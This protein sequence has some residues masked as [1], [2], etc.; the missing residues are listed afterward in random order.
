MFENHIKIPIVTHSDDWYKF[1]TVGLT[2][3]E[4]LK[5]GLDRPLA[6]GIGSSEVGKVC[7]VDEYRPTKAELYHEKIGSKEIEKSDSKFAFHGRHM[8]PHIK[9]F[10]T[11]YDNTEDGYLKI[12]DDWKYKGI[13]PPRKAVDCNYY[14]INP[15]YPYMFSS[16]DYAIPPG[17]TNLITGEVLDR[18]C[19]LECKTITYWAARPWEEHIPP[20]YLYQVN[21]QMLVTDSYYAEIPILMD[22]VNFDV[23]KVERNDEICRIIVKRCEEFWYKRVLPAREALAKLEEFRK[24]GRK[25]S[26]SLEEQVQCYIQRLEPDVDGTIASDEYL[27]ESFKK[28]RES[29]KGSFKLYKIA[30]EAKFI[31]KIIGELSKVKKEKENKLKKIHTDTGSEYIDFGNSSGYTRFYQKSNSQ[32]NQLD[33]RV[34]PGPNSERVLAELE[35]ISLKGVVSEFDLQ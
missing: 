12:Y 32:S 8:E 25:I 23:K 16:L 6:G 13:E 26:S 5:Y 21:Q 31:Q 10:W 11:C 1:R 15:D 35:K 24:N 9:D 7:G 29:I 2:K 28:E 4:A 17:Q 14:L 34:K 27:A 33:N 20:K 18:Y 19:P 3:E 30:S 22:G